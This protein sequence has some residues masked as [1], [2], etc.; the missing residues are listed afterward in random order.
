MN[1][2]G[3][4]ISRL[5]GRLKVCG[6]ATYAGDFKL[7]GVAHAR[8]LLSTVPHGRVARI[9][10]TAAEA[11]PGVLAVLTPAN[12]QRLPKKGQVGAV[13]PEGRPL[14]LL[15]D[16][17]VLYNGQPIAVVVAETLEQAIAATELLRVSY[18]ADKPV[19]DFKT[20]S[21]KTHAPKS[22]LSQTTDSQ[23]GNHEAGLR[24]AAAVLEAVYTT[25][26]EHHNPMEP[27]ATIASW[28]GDA[29]TLHDST[30]YVS[31]VQ[32][33]AARTFGLSE[34]AVTVVCPYVGGGFGCK[35]STWSHVL[36][37]AMAA[38]QVNR[39]VKLVL[40]R[41]QMYGPVGNRPKTQQT[42]LLAASADGA[43]TA[44]EHTVVAETSFLEDWIEPSALLTRMLYACDN[45][46]TTHR[47]ARMHVGTPTYQRAPGEAS[48]SYALECSLDELAQRLNIDPLQMRLRNHAESDAHSGLPFSSKSLR[49]CYR[50]GAER[51]DWARRSAPP[52]SMRNGRWQVGL[53]M[54]TATYPTNR[55]PAEALCRLMADGT[56]LVQCGSQDLGTGTYTVMTQVAADALG[57]PLGKVRFELGDS[58]LPKAPVSGGSQTAASVAPA[59]QAACQAARQKL[60]DIALADPRSAL[61]GSAR[62]SVVAVD[63][64]LQSRADATRRESIASALAR[65]GQMIEAQAKSEPGAEKKAFS[66][67][68]FG[69]VFAEVHVDAEL[70]IVR[71]PRIVGA[72]GV[73]KLLNQ[74][75]GHSQ[76]MGGIVWGVGMALYEETHRDLRNGRVING[77]LGE[78]HVPI[79]AD[80]GA[81]EIIVVAEDDPHIN[82]LGAKGI[83]E[84]G[85]TG[86]PGAIGN[87]IFHATGKRIRDLPITLDK[88]I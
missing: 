30:Q 81:I 75:M 22:A 85:I 7:P 87:A 24:A 44:V 18:A 50:A 84:I 47:V 1:M 72:Y 5:D 31:G 14:T 69:A 55:S 64:W 76:L 54:G 59:V 83:G 62:G 41:T 42:M 39:P 57:L 67:H 4:G 25:P 13:P 48:G 68:S 2:T 28:S 21:K 36:L 15:Q 51:I 38:R 60:I 33:V 37:A 34:S 8:L 65:H 17:R 63:G 3:E 32:T 6:Q 40:D 52:G 27:H 66:M 12:A 29:L 78:Y 26:V 46:R 35:G 80:I 74:K 88:L 56:A 61:Q 9:D 70:G 19:V 79:N 86:V 71:V 10:T 58:R 20:A 53:G 16:D 73:G 82:P 11:A 23:R 45:L 43:L 49:E 77:N